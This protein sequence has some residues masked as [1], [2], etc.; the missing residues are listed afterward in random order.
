[1]SVTGIVAA[2][3]AEARTLAPVQ[4]APGS[5]AAPPITALTRDRLLAVSG[6]GAPA[7]ARAAEA[8]VAAGA[9]GLLSFGLAGAL[10]PQLRAGS[11]VLALTALGGTAALPADAPWREHLA[12]QAAALPDPPR[13]VS[14]PV[15][16]VTQPLGSVAAKTQARMRSGASAVDMESRAIAEVAAR[17]GVKFAI[18]RV[19]IDTADDALPPSLLSATDSFGA[20]RPLRLLG[21]LAGSP[22]DLAALLRLAQRYRVALHSL[23]RLAQLDL[24]LP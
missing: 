6:M 18:A 20:V 12:E 22:A 1:M 10:D 3:T 13:V 17:R 16:G 11:W 24:R 14:G 9:H 21:A 4:A 2:L 19:V 15:L 5:A 7:A 23:R 8:L